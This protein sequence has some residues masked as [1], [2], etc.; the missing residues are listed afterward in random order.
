[1]AETIQNKEF[2]DIIIKIIESIVGSRIAETDF[3][4]NG[5]DIMHDTTIPYHD[6]YYEKKYNEFTK[7][8]NSKKEE[9]KN[10]KKA[11]PTTEI[12]Y[13][14]NIYRELIALVGRAGFLPIGYMDGVIEEDD[15]RDNPKVQ[16][17]N[18]KD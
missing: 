2:P 4:M 18:P 9:E 12:N 5:V 10:I 1:M 14:K 15:L 6:A 8:F 11:D 17:K 7:K 16:S 13:Y 3:W